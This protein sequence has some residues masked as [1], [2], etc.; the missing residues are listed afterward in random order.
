MNNLENEVNP[1]QEIKDELSVVQDVK[2]EVKDA[3]ESKLDESK[4]ISKKCNVDISCADFSY[5][6]L[7]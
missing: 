1:K 3:A 7:I 2:V 6:P 4:K 5:D